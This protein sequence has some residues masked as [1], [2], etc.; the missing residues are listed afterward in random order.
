MSQYTARGV[1]R[2]GNAADPVIPA[3]F[4]EQ[5]AGI[6]GLDDLHS[7][8]QH[9]VGA[10]TAG[11]THYLAPAD[12]AV[13]YDIAPL[14]EQGT[15]G[16]GSAI[17]VLARS[18]L[19]QVDVADFRNAFGL[20]TNAPVVLVNGADPGLSNEADFQETE[21]DVEW[22]GA[23]A[24][25]ATVD[26]VA[27]ASTAT[28]DG[29]LLSAEY[30]VDHDVASVIALS[31]AECESDLGQA[32]NAMLAQLWEQA[33]VEGMSVVV[34]AGDAGAAGCDDATE[35]MATEGRAVNGM[36][37]TPYSICVGGTEFAE[38][39]GAFWASD[40]N[41][42]G[43][44]ALAYIPET[45]WN[46]S[47][48]SGS[49]AAGLWA[50]GGGVSAV[51]ARP[52]W[53]T[54]VAGTRRA[55]PDVSLSSAGHDPYLVWIDGAQT[56]DSG[57][58]AA[59]QVFAGIAAL[60]VEEKGERLGNLNAALYAIAAAHPSAFHDVV[61]GNNSVPGVNGFAAGPRYDE[62]TGLGSVDAALLAE[63]WPA[64]WKQFGKERCA[65]LWSCHPLPIRPRALTA[66]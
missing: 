41:A 59:A 20:G 50:G 65:T 8:P 5:I 31:Y 25:K 40:N 46:E 28:M 29:I 36:C 13:I 58:S 53:Q 14:Y 23:M 35:L 26:V 24:P 52:A 47:G 49:G 39:G 7:G 2:I 44:S 34:A 21:L 48:A 62:A 37:S 10:F 60:L 15:M 30:A 32:G 19:V 27:S 57:T 6:V 55:V 9:A 63:D 61:T 64:G 42:D 66:P 45:A 51:Y 54:G 38:A 1:E 18:N 12:V 33:A 11:A 17:A 56:P 4:A 3:E 16:A 43:R 22:A